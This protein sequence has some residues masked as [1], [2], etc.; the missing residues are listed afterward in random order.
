MAAAAESI[1]PKGNT[2]SS[3]QV[4]TKVPFLLKYQLRE[5]QHI[6]LDWLV[7]MFEKNLNGILADEMG[8]GKTIQTIS[9]IAHLACE[10]GIWGPHLIVVPTSVMLNWE[11]EF[12]K[13]CPALKILTYYGNPKERRI[14]R[15]GWTKPNTFHV[16][17]TSYKLVVQDHQ[18]F[19]RKKW[20]YFI[21]DEAQHI[22][23]FQSQRWQMLLNFNSS[24]RLLLTGTPLQNNLMDLWSLMHFLMPNV[25]QSHREFKDWFV[26]PVTGMVEGNNEKNDE[27]IRRLHKVLRPFLLRRL[28]CDVEKQ[29]PK[30]YEHIVPCSLSKRQR[31]LYDEFMSLGK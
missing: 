22:K 30:K 11:M 27:L 20:I 7:A 15:K 16:C 14:K 29:L 8:L 5:Y 10:K 28:K 4:I 2:L 21:L 13:W 23:N 26:N 25:F 12:K 18:S 9:L 1:Q 6:G 3:V 31:L 24:R 19:R 17:I